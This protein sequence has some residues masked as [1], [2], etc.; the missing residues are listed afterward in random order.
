M[1][2][3]I[4]LACAVISNVASNVSLKLGMTRAAARAA[5]LPEPTLVDKL[6]A[7]A[8][9]P[10]LWAGFAGAG[11]LLGFY[12]L[13]LQRLPVTVAYTTVTV[14]AMLALAVAAHFVLGERFGGLKAAG[15][16]LAALGVLLMILD[17]VRS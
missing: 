12:L 1:L 3:W 16:L 10:A 17:T 13:A 2:G 15:L 4:F 14:S 9:E 5:A 6:W 11:A 7:H 8:S